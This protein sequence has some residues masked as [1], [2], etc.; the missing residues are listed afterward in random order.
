MFEGAESKYE[1]K[2]RKCVKYYDSIIDD[3]AW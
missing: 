2:K 3:A 1:K